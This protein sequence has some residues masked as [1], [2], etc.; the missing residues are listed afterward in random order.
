MRA[1]ERL[2]ALGARERDVDVA[3]A[4][5]QGRT[6]AEIAAE[7][8]TRASNVKAHVSDILAGPGPVDRVRIA[9]TAQHAG[10]A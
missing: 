8:Y 3:A 10:D 1:R 4:V 2:A 7:L 6:N 9:R 5:G